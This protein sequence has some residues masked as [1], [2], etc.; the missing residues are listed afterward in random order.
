[1]FLVAAELGNQA[2]GVASGISTGGAFGQRQTSKSW[3]EDE[4]SKEVERIQNQ[5]IA[6]H[7]DDL[8]V[9]GRPIEQNG[10]D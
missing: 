3:S 8:A 6:E 4:Q 9:I 7:P 5:F 1:M 10:T 2:L